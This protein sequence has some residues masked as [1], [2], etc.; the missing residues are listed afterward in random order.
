MI[1]SIK[2]CWVKLLIH[3][4]TS[5]VATYIVEPFAFVHFVPWHHHY[6]CL[7]ILIMHVFSYFSTCPSCECISICEM[8]TAVQKNIACWLYDPRVM[9]K[10]ICIARLCSVMKQLMFV[11]LS[12]FK[13]VYLQINKI[14]TIWVAAIHLHCVNYRWTIH[15]MS[16]YI[17]RKTIFKFALIF[18]L[19]LE[20]H[21]VYITY[22]HDQSGRDWIGHF[23]TISQLC[24]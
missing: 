17:K 19:Y 16:R 10:C 1:T 18:M 14:I 15:V 8:F 24:P 6:H 2:K 4:Q 23:I 3:T 9:Y 7:V 5:A 13:S 12:S 11:Y 20:S 22:C 21:F